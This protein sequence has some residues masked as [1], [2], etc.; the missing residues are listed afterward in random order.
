MGGF[1][2]GG[3]GWEGDGVAGVL[4]AYEG[5]SKLLNAFGEVALHEL[6]EG[7]GGEGGGVGGV[8]NGGG[9]GDG[10]VLGDVKGVDAEGVVNVNGVALGGGDIVKA[11]HG[12]MGKVGVVCGF[13]ID[14]EVNGLRGAQRGGRRR[15][16]I[17][18]HRLWSRGGC[19][20]EGRVKEGKEKG[21]EGK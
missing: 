2:G 14:G 8:V 11:L 9:D 7:S 10:V 6:A 1:V 12:R 3:K 16:G 4:V 20:P 17:V 21:E 18:G 13:A 5:A 15:V 19:G